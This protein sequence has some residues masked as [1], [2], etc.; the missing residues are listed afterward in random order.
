MTFHV[1]YILHVAKRGSIGKE[2]KRKKRDEGNIYQPWTVQPEVSFTHHNSLIPLMTL[3][4]H[5]NPHV[6]KD[7]L[8]SKLAILF[9]TIKAAVTEWF[10]LFVLQ[11][12]EDMYKV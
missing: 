8:K 11:G 3:L 1:S 6:L 9:K 10:K 7:M 2:G 4:H 12:Q 5:R